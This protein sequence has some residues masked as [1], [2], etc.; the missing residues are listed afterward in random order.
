MHWRVRINQDLI[1]GRGVE[2]ILK[3]ASKYL[4]TET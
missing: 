1:G 4:V 3:M 2:M